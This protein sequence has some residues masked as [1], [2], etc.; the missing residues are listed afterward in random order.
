MACT[1][2]VV[3]V[4]L[5][6]ALTGDQGQDIVVLALTLLDFGGLEKPKV[7][8][9]SSTFKFWELNFSRCNVQVPF[10]FSSFQSTFWGVPIWTNDTSTDFL[11]L[12]QRNLSSHY[13]AF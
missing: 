13:L 5:Q 6:L 7:F 3:R 8:S 1:H 2:L 9:S 10:Q 12:I 11:F 4:L